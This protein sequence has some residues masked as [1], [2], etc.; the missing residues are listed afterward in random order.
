MKH[1]HELPLVY[2]AAPYTNPDP[3]E[4]TNVI[5]RVASALLDEGLCAPVV[6]HVSL[7]W[8]L[9]TPRP[10]DFWLGID[11]AYLARCDAV[12]RLPGASSGADGEVDFAR[13]LGIPVHFSHSALL[14]WLNSRG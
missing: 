1:F 4:N 11:L 7:L 12:W 6:P 9:V 2:L 10:Y 14:H 13:A 8:H 3:V 5:C